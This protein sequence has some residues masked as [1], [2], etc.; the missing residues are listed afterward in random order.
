VVLVVLGI[1]FLCFRKLQGVVFPAAIILMSVVFTLGLMGFCGVPI[2]TVGTTIPVL[3]VAIVSAYCI[4]Q[5]NHY[6]HD[7]RTDK[8]E[9]LRHNM[10]TVGLAIGL[11]GLTVMVGFGALAIEE[12][13]PIKNFGIFTAI[14]DL[15]GLVGALYVL[16]ALILVAGRPKKVL[17]P[18]SDKG[19]V[20]RILQG[21][22]WL[23]RRHY[24]AVLWV[25]A[26][27]SVT[28]LVGGFFVE[29]ELNNVSFFKK[30]SPIH[31]ADDHLNQKL[32][33]TMVMNVILD[34]DLSHPSE[35]AAVAVGEG[36][37]AAT[38]VVLTNPAVL[39]RVEQF[40]R[41]VRRQFPFVTKVNSFNTVLKKMH[42]EMNGGGKE[43]YAIPQDP[44][45]ISQYLLIFSGD[46]QGVLTADHDKLRVSLV[47]KRVSS[48]QVEQVRA[49]CQRYFTPDFQQ[50]NHLQVQVSG[51]AHLFD[52]AN[53][54]LV[55]G[56]LLSIVVCLAIVLLLLLVVLGDLRMSLI[57]LTPIFVTLLINF[58]SL[59]FFGIPLNTGTAIVSSIA[60]GIGVD[61]SIHFITWY[62]N[63]LRG[64]ADIAAALEHSIIHK[65]R[66]ILYN[67]FVIFGGFL[68]LVVSQFV[69]LIQFGSL[70]ALCMVTTAVGALVVVP[71]LIRALAARDYRFLY[72]GTKASNSSL[73]K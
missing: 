73:P 49:F 31:A 43:F 53:R 42:Q 17:G 71:A 61:Y 13:V 47:M 70:V 40:D 62:R 34:S 46:L 20:S 67:M 23:N 15:A 27:L 24:R 16:P 2:S 38:P 14:G 57:A 7:Q 3:L 12:F 65:G 21:F 68:V 10:K 52:V 28:F 56:M 9:V 37:E 51:T 29:A 60:I 48:A 35:R 11:S 59:G 41:D 19:W 8:L 39:N 22:V 44:E 50:A 45:L 36:G 63:E 54:L 6:L 55:E 72:L 30:A 69:P 18:E 25:S 64:R 4:H 32:A 33:G 1:L 58:G 66:A 5:M 26:V